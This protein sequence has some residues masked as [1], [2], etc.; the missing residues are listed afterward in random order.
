M[1]ANKMEEI[2]TIPLEEIDIPILMAIW[3]KEFMPLFGSQREVDGKI[4]IDLI[5]VTKE[6]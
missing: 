5:K 2:V 1:K 4:C 6:D 3:Y